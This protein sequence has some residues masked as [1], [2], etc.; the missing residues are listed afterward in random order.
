MAVPPPLPDPAKA[1][2]RAELR[3]KRAAHVASLGPDGA[4]R[5]AEIAA[6]RMLAH[7]PARAIVS[8]Y[9]AIEDELDPN[10]LIAAL[11]NRGHA[12]ALPTLFDRTTMRFLAW[13]PG[14]PLE[15]GPMDLRQPLARAPERAPDLIVTPLVGFDR[16]GGRIGYG[17]GHYDRAFQQFPGA[18]RIGFAWAVQEIECVPHDPWDVR[19][20]AVVTEQEF[21]SI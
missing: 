3:A 19:V 9:L 20:H 13:Q 14:D 5:A 18:H 16:A 4:R 17:A 6:G 7:I 10:A 12:L 15:R 21:V 2:L 8:L 11:H 1:A